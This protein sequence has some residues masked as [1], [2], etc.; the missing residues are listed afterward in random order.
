MDEFLQLLTPGAYMRGID[1]QDCFH[2]PLVAPK[3]R[4]YLRVRHP[5]SGILGVYLPRPFGLS[6]SPGWNDECVRAVLVVACAQFPQ[7]RMV[8]FVGDIR[9]VGASGEH[10]ALAVGMTDFTSLTRSG[11]EV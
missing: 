11:S 9:F 5:M 6:P 8:D 4:R 10:D 2:Q 1:L 3:R 7:L